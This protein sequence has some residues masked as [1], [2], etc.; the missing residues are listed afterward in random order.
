MLPL[1]IS[2]AYQ[3]AEKLLKLTNPNWNRLWYLLSLFGV[4]K[5][6][7][8]LLQGRDQS[9]ESDLL[10]VRHVLKRVAMET[11]NTF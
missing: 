9:M 7:D 3:V 8:L 1:Q 4:I 5:K 2:G 11:C 10:Q 6:Q